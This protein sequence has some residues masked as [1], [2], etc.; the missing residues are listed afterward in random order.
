MSPSLSP[1][2]GACRCAHLQQNDGGRILRGGGVSSDG[3]AL[4]TPASQTIP[5]SFY[6]LKWLHL[7][8]QNVTEDVGVHIS[9]WM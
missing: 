8:I 5:R 3:E 1:L 2:G 4:T 7:M 9:G 6:S